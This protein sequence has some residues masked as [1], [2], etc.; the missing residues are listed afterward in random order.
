MYLATSKTLATAGHLLRAQFIDYMLRPIAPPHKNKHSAR[1]ESPYEGSL[2]MPIPICS[3]LFS[4][5]LGALS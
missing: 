4:V 2:M 3:A 1:V 5:A